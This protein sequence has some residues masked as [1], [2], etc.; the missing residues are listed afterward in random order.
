M[1]LRLFGRNAIIYWLNSEFFSIEKAKNVKI[2]KEIMLNRF[3]TSSSSE[4][5]VSAAILPKSFSI[6]KIYRF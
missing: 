6:T 4:T 5:V 2:N 1:A 3:E